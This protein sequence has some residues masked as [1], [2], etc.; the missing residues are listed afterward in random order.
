MSIV[1]SDKGFGVG[2]NVD[3]GEKPVPEPRQFLLVEV[4]PH[5]REL[6]LRLYE[7]LEENRSPAAPSYTDEV[8]APVNSMIVILLVDKDGE[9]AL[10]QQLTSGLLWVTE[11]PLPFEITLS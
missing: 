6:T 8:S 2:V 5:L 4:P 3:G 11:H 1:V 7:A 10:S 9:A